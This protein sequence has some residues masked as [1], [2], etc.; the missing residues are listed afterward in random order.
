[1]RPQWRRFLA[2][3]GQVADELVSDIPG[4]DRSLGALFLVAQFAGVV[5]SPRASAWPTPNAATRTI[6]V[7]MVT[8]GPSSR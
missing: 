5:S 4:F 1:M 8:T 2:E 7:N 6:I 3:F